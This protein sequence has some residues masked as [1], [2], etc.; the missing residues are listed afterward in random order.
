MHHF[1]RIPLKLNSFKSR[2][3]CKSV[4]KQFGLR[5]NI[6]KDLNST[7]WYKVGFISAIK[8]ASRFFCVLSI[9]V[10]I[11]D[12]YEMKMHEMLDSAIA[13]SIYVKTTDSTLVQRLSS[14]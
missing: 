14:T 4:I 7:R 3:T 12:V 6:S 2:I 5:D 11:K 13:E 1:K 8:K 10:I 9:L